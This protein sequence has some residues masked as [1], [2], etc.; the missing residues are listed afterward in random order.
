MFQAAERT[1]KGSLNGSAS[2]RMPMGGLKEMGCPFPSESGFGEIRT[3]P[4]ACSYYIQSC[5]S[6][7]F[8]LI[9]TELYDSAVP[10]Q[11]ARNLKIIIDR[12]VGPE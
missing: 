2:L 10:V 8:L 3:Y 11:V 4:F 5:S 12:K 9:Q 1:K 6:F 7:T